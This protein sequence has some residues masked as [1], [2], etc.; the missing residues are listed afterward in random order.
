MCANRKINYNYN[1]RRKLVAV[2]GITG[3]YLYLKES[4]KKIR[5]KWAKKWLTQRNILSHIPLLQELRD[6]PQD[7]K[8]YL[9]MP[10]SVI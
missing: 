3:S 7:F 9:R 1:D 6:E 2:L 10:Q 5:S 4:R 8:N